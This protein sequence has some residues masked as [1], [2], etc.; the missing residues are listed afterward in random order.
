MAGRTIEDRLRQEYFDLLPEL[1]RTVESLQAQ[2]QYH[3]LPVA[4]QLKNHESLLVKSRVKACASAID[5]IR[6]RNF[7]GVFN[8]EKPDIYTLKTLRDLVGIRILVFPSQRAVEID[9]ILRSEFPDWIADPVIDKVTGQN[10]AYK[11]HGPYLHAPAGLHCE[12]QIASILTGLFWEVEH[13]AIY[14]PTP[15]LKGLIDSP[16]MQ[17]KTADVYRALNAFEEEFERQLA[18]SDKPLQ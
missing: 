16:A 7:G 17:D 13:A 1:D 12:Y 5:A 9:A 8:R 2:I 10:L 3:L 14:K 18:K 4:R 6:R 11:Y 15:N